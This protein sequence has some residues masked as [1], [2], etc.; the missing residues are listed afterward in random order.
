MSAKDVKGLTRK[1]SGKF[2]FDAKTAKGS[3]V[4]CDSAPSVLENPDSLFAKCVV[5]AGSTAE[6]LSLKELETNT[7][8]EAKIDSCYIANEPFDPNTYPDIGLVPYTSIPCVLDFLKQRYLV[9]QIYTTADPLLVA[10]NPFKDVGLVGNDVILNYR[11]SSDV[12]KLPPHVFAI[13]KRAFDNIMS[14]SR[15]Q[16]ILVC[17]ESGAGKTEATKHVMKF[18]ASSKSGTMD[19]KIQNAIMAANPVLEAF[20]NAKTIRNNNSSRFGRF[21]QLQLG[22][23]GGIEYGVVRNFL[24]EKSRVITQEGLERS[25]HI[26]YQLIKGADTVPG[27][28]EKLKLKNLNEYKFINPECLDVETIDDV[29]DFKDV[30]QSFKTMGL[31]DSQ[32]ED[33]LSLVSGILLLGNVEIEPEDVGGGVEG[34]KIAESSRESFNNSMELCK[35]DKEAVEKE[36]IIKISYAGKNVIEGRFRPDETRMLKDSLA[37]GL[38]DKLFDYIILNLNENIKPPSGFKVFCGML[39]IFGFE[40][41]KNNSLEQFFINVTNE[42]LQKNFTDIVFEK[43]QS[44][45]S[46]EGISAANLEFKSNKTVLEALCDKKN[47][48]LSAMEDQC[49]VPNGSDEKFLSAAYTNLKSNPC[50]KP[51]KIGG[52][53]NFIVTHTIGDIQYCATGFLFKNKDV[54]RAELVEVVQK[55]PNKLVADLFKDVFVERGKMAKGQL[56]GSQFMNS[57][58]SLMSIV[59]ET[60]PHFIRCVKPNET[61]KPLDW[62][63]SKVLI[64]LHSLSILEALQLRNLGFSYRRTFSEFIFQFKYCNMAIANDTQTDPKVLAEKMLSGTDIPK[65]AWAI[66]KTMVFLS[67]D[68][69]KRMAQIQREK[70]SAFEP[71]VQ[72]LEAVYLRYKLRREFRKNQLKPLTRIQ[73]QLRRVLDI[74]I[75]VMN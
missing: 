22:K 51:A 56:I 58:G 6:K 35:L 44:L 64:Q 20:G 70:L 9:N 60:E 1:V 45:Y 25:Y 65:N 32:I 29:Q 31:S 59:N 71:L 49:L 11:D 74:E 19:L 37:K 14:V 15:S 66:G 27:L 52:D 39:D 36:L 61:K 62:L 30:M 33:I 7:T 75:S 24:L 12:S 54:L 2:V 13:A 34:A 10:I 67:K 72:L 50:L 42:Y 47:S 3:T 57:L 46:S 43:E 26:F 21:M 55:S 40:V 5:Q 38:Y 17:G 68:A 18:F 4:W 28:K 8:F 69:A 41:F 63:A 53:V 73:A 23:M 48:I 16:S